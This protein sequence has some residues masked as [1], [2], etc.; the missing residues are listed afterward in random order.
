MAE[1]ILSLRTKL[2]A[3]GT[4]IILFIAMA[5]VIKIQ[6][7]MLIQQ[8]A[9]QQSI[10]EFKKLG[11]DIARAQTQLVTKQDLD[12]LTDDQVIQVYQAAYQEAQRVQAAQQGAVSS[13]AATTTP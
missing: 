5:I 11:D 12:Q 4:V 1:E 7:N 9:M 6:Y 10:I 13:G 2:I 8:Q 3:A